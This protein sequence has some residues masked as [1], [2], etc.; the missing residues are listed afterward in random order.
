[1]GSLNYKRV[2]TPQFMLYF[3]IS[4]RHARRKIEEMLVDLGK[5]KDAPIFLFEFCK[6]TKQTVEAA[7]AI[8]G[9][10]AP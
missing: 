5:E 2:R 10:K 6:C 8:F 1:M 3:D 4:D 9:W 7:A